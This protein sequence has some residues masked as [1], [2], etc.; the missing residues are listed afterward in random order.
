MLGA[1]Y[2]LFLCSITLTKLEYYPGYKIEINSG[3]Q[4]VFSITYQD[5]NVTEEE[6]M[7]KDNVQGKRKMSKGDAE[8]VQ[9]KM[10]KDNVPVLTDDELALPLEPFER[11]SAKDKKNRRRQAIIGMIMKD[12]HVSLKMMSEKL[13]VN[14]KTIWRDLNELKL[15]GVIERIGDDFTGEWKVC[16][17]KL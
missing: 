13:D 17:K 3:Q 5:E 14:I 16:K 9:G 11:L 12:S 10:A 8:N 2:L 4:F 7:S 15:R 1:G 6:K